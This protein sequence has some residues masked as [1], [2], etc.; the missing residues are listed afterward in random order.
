MIEIKEYA[1]ANNQFNRLIVENQVY[2][3]CSGVAEL[4]LRIDSIR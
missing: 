2:Y 4:V 1:D 3:H